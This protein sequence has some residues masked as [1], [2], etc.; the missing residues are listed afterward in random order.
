MQ[1]RKWVNQSGIDQYST[2]IVLSGFNS[3]LVLLGGKKNQDAQHGGSHIK[4]YA[5]Y[6]STDI[7]DL[8]DEIPF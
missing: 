4:P 5:G 1:T 8:D 3:K 6:Q 2:E 7:D